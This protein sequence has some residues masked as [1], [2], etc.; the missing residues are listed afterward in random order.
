[1]TI[2]HQVNCI[3]ELTGDNVFDSE[4]FNSQLAVIQ[5]ALGIESGD[6]AGIYFSDD[7]II[8]A[9]SQS[10]TRR[11][12]IIIRYISSELQVELLD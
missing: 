12:E 5:K 6:F 11:I 9:W 10:R 8:K 4:G 2:I 7:A 3:C 1:M